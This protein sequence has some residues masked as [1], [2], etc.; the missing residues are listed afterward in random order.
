MKEEGEVR[1]GRVE[2]ERKKTGETVGYTREAYRDPP[3]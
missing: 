3:K 1:E 2:F